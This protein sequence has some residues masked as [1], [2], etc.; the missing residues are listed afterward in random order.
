MSI[1]LYKIWGLAVECKDQR[2][3]LVQN[4]ITKAKMWN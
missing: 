3:K 1:I 4:R 2:A